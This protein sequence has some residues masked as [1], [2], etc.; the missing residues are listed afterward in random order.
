MAYDFQKLADVELLEEVP[1]GA[2]AFVAVDGVV[3]RVP[4][5]GLGGGG[6][7]T[8]IL[9]F[10][11]E[12][13]TPEKAVMRTASIPVNKLPITCDNYT[14]AQARAV[15]EAGDPF[16]AMIFMSINNMSGWASCSQIVLS[17]NCIFMTFNDGDEQTIYWNAEGF[18]DKKPKN[19]NP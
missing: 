17:D 19:S 13:N 6:V 7:A 8:A 18:F 11:S 2:S 3:K 5:S 16:A 14:Y 4:G 10:A 15:L 12:S 1:D 9:R